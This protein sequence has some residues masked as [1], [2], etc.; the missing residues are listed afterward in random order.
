MTEPPPP[1]TTPPTSPHDVPSAVDLLRA[2]REFLERDVVPVTEGRLKFDARVG[3]N[4]LAMVVR[5]LELGPAMAGAHAQRLARL[6]VE[7]DAALARAIRTGAFD[8]RLDE[9]T[10]LVRDSV[11]DKLRVANPAYM[12]DTDQGP[13]ALGR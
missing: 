2:V 11:V 6:G 5:E 8:D 12:G 9:V 10:A 4:V 1:P 3:A 13:D 7:D